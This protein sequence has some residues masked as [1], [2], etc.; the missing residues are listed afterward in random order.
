MRSQSNIT[1]GALRTAWSWGLGYILRERMAD[2]R[3]GLPLGTIAVELTSNYEWFEVLR[4]EMLKNEETADTHGNSFARADARRSMIEYYNGRVHLR[5]QGLG[6]DPLVQYERDG[7]ATLTAGGSWVG[8]Y[9]LATLVYPELETRY[10]AIDLLDQIAAMANAIASLPRDQR[11]RTTN[12]LIP[13]YHGL[14]E[15]LT[16][17]MTKLCDYIENTEGPEVAMVGHQVAVTNN[18]SRYSML[19]V[20]LASIR[21]GSISLATSPLCSLWT[22]R[23]IRCSEKITAPAGCL[24]TTSEERSHRI[25]DAISRLWTSDSNRQS[26]WHR[27]GARDST[28]GFAPIRG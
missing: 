22:Q 20:F 24:S 17:D 28:A 4:Q 15:D 13:V 6:N 26:R 9:E 21:L 25:A 12:A 14:P 10:K 19:A 8:C 3:V 23:A 11:E 7:L 16:R 2:W 18:H 5:V 27:R 1:A